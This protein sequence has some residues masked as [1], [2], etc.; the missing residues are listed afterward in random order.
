[1]N[2]YN[3]IMHIT[4]EINK[5]I[6][7]YIRLM[8]PG[9]LE[10]SILEDNNIKK[11]INELR[12]IGFIGISHTLIQ[13]YKNFFTAIKRSVY[14]GSRPNRVYSPNDIIHYKNVINDEV[15]KINEKTSEKIEIVEIN[16]QLKID[17]FYRRFDK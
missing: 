12:K 9:I 2:D 1:M 15:K 8:E 3:K 16:D 11:Y 10:G 14:R 7:S 13:G 17:I 6:N 4:N 5:F